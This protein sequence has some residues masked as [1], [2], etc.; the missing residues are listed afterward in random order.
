MDSESRNGLQAF[1]VAGGMEE[2]LD[3][4][5]WQEMEKLAHSMVDDALSYLRTVRSRPV[6]RPV[7]RDVKEH[8]RLPVPRTG[9]GLDEAYDEFVQYVLPYVTGN[10]HPRFWAW[11]IG[12]GSAQGMMAEMLAACMNVNVGGAEHA[13]PYVE[14]Q[15]I[16]WLKAMLGFPA[17]AS[18]VLVSGASTANLLGLAVARTAK[19]GFDVRRE[20]LAGRP[21]MTVYGSEE[22]H[23]SVQRAVEL[24]GLGSAGLRLIP[25]DAA[26][27]I[28]LAA[29]AAAIAADRTAGLRPIA[30]VGSAGAVNTGAFDDLAALADLCAAEGLWLHVDGAFGALAALSPELRPLTAGM[31]RADSLAF[32]LHK[33]MYMPYQVACVLVRSEQQHRNTFS[34]MPEYLAH[35]GDRGLAAGDFWLSD[36]SLELSRSFRALKVW[37]LLKAEGADK[38]GR[39]IQQ[40][41][42][43]CRY[44]VELIEAAPDLELTAPAPLNIVCFRYNPG[45]LDEETLDRLNQ[46]LL[47]RLYESGVAAPSYT[48][49]NGRYTLR[50]ANTN[51]RSQRADFALLVETVRRLG[52]AIATTY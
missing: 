37:L 50:V 23:S 32:D 2:T 28:D 26:Y 15:V 22:L 1:D 7:P 9:Q 49:L 8:M 14:E 33:W 36:Y 43:Q 19:A 52:A 45:G 34:L 27:R 5:D 41:V 17:A 31:E 40:N 20:G 13:A 51:H 12:T 44:L 46:E 25:T 21:Q 10:I 11:V 47:L 48:T 16:N 29:L 42:E 30:V 4:A 6:W 18:G 3:P 39:L 38:Y 24:L 35:G